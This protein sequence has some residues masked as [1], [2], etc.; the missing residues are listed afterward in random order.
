MAND[1]PADVIEAEKRI[2][3]AQSSKAKKPPTKKQREALQ[4][5]VE[6][7]ER[8]NSRIATSPTL[9]EAQAEQGSKLGRP[10]TFTQELADEICEQLAMGLS[11]RTVCKAEHMPAMST[12]FKWLR[13]NDDFSEQYARAKEEAADAMAE[14]L[15]DISDDGTN[16][17]MEINRGDYTSWITNG[18]ALQRSRLRV[19]TRKFLMSKMKPKRYGDKLTLDGEQT[20]NHKFKDMD[21]EQLDAAIKATKDKIA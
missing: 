19:E 7:V 3:K 12:V 16:D 20:I 17:W 10:S 21:D 8:Y 11:M 2:A 13:E 5:D 14:D 15:L 1:K 6:L 18:E 4:A 9:E